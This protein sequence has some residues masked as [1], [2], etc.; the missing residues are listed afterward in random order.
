MTGGRFSPGPGVREPSPAVSSLSLPACPKR[1]FRKDSF[2]EPLKMG[3]PPWG[4]GTR[5]APP[6]AA[7]RA[8]SPSRRVLRRIPQDDVGEG[9]IKGGRSSATGCRTCCEPGSS[10]DVSKDSVHLPANPSIARKRCRNRGAS[11]PVGPHALPTLDLPPTIPIYTAKSPRC[12]VLFPLFSE[13]GDRERKHP[14]QQQQ[15]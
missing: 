6:P 7:R 8:R 11:P 3:S 12:H 13:C 10:H 4:R 15:P 5:T 1:S 14:Q 9:G 2:E